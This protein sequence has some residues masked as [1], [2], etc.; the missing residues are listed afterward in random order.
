MLRE[1]FFIRLLHN[2]YDS[3]EQFTLLMQD[4]DIPFTYAAYQCCYFEMRNPSVDAM[5]VPFPSVPSL[6]VRLRRYRTH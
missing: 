5:G 4:L 6:P 3:A 2:L 1:K